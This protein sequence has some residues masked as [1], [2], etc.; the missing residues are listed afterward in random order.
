[1]ESLRAGKRP[2]RRLF[3]LDGGRGFESIIEAAGA[4]PVEMA[5]RDVLDHMAKGG[6][7]QGVVLEGGPLVIRKLA[8]W[9]KGTIPEDALIVILDGVED[10]HNFG[11]VIRS[12]AACGASGVLFG[13]DRAAPLSPVAAKAAAGGM[14]YVDLLQETNLPRAVGMLQDAGFWVAGLDGEGEGLLWDA[15]LAGRIALIVGSEGRGVRRLLLE[16]CDWRL[17]IPLSGPIT[18][19]NASVSAGIALAECLRQRQQT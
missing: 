7:H 9:L 16:R 6:N 11:A 2:L 3:L 18:S 5:R 15:D 12:A 19:L 10:P 14:E 1:L 4:L 8:E 17:R 13:K